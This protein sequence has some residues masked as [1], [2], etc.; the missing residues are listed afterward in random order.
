MVKHCCWCW[1][2]KCRDAYGKHAEKQSCVKH[3][4]AHSMALVYG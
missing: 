2:G 3:N 1:G 4:G